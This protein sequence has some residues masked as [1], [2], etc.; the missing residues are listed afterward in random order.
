MDLQ[1]L[2]DGCI[3]PGAGHGQRRKSGTALTG[4]ALDP[5]HR[6]QHDL[7][8]L[9]S[10][11]DPGS[12]ERDVLADP[13]NPHLG[14]VAGND[15]RAQHTLIGGWEEPGIAL[16]HL[17]QHVHLAVGRVA[18]DLLDDAA[19]RR[20][21]GHHNKSCWMRNPDHRVIPARHR[22]CFPG[23]GVGWRLHRHLQTTTPEKSIADGGRERHQRDPSQGEDLRDPEPPQVPALA[24]HPHPGGRGPRL[25][26]TPCRGTESPENDA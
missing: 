13:W 5:P 21:A 16:I 17:N 23:G 6:V 24:M 26:P 1:A 8:A 2:V 18:S 7:I 3:R 20:T 19:H 25:P 14:H 10:V 15:G 12:I 9:V 4:G 22:T 11:P